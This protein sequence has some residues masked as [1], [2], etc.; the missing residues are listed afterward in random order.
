MTVELGHATTIATS[1]SE[2]SALLAW[3]TVDRRAAFR[4]RY[5]VYIAEQR[6]PYPE[7]NH[8]DR[9]LTDELD[10]EGEIVIV[11]DK[12]EVLGTVRTN[13]LAS[14]LA[15]AKYCEVLGIQE[16]P[17]MN[18]SRSVVSSRL[19]TNAGH[20]R[21]VVRSMLFE[22]IYEHQLTRGTRHCFAVCA[23][24]LVR[25]F[26]RYGFREYAMPIHDAIAGTLHRTLLVLDD[27]DHLRGIH[28][29]FVAIAEKLGVA[30]TPDS[31][32]NQL[33]QN[34]KGCHANF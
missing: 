28:S 1:C 4:L 22:K 19:A 16:L 26:R 10:A 18:L 11:K 30:A 25:M 13:S 7:A 34:Y 21:A 15:H 27:L 9:I 2:A 33:F 14:P 6:K 12:G 31:Q 29:P 3:H 20:R 32:L 8:E 24:P 17:D 5:E 23:P